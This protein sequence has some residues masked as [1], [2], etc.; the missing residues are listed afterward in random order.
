V[1]QATKKL[2]EQ[3]FKDLHNAER[4]TALLAS[5]YVNSKRDK[6]KQPKPVEYMDFCFYRQADKTQSATGQNGAAM[7]ELIKQGKNPSWALFCYKAITSNAD[8]V[9][10]GAI[11]AL[12]AEDAM[13]L[14]PIKTGS[15]Y[16]GLL[17]ALESASNK[18]QKFTSPCGIQ[19]NMRVPHVETKVVAREGERL[20]II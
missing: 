8:K 9:F 17:I 12:V 4:P 11:V 1:L 6:K 10:T 18:V 13:L 15:A 20:M 19:I 7:L 2:A 5:I 16:T 3:K 14:N